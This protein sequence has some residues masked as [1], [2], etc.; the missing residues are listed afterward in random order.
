MNTMMYINF[1]TEKQ[2]KILLEE[3]KFIEIP[4]IEKKLACGDIGIGGIADTDVIYEKVLE[5]FK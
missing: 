4:A 3:F 2:R 1:L 5:Y